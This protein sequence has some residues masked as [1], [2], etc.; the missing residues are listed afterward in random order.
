MTLHTYK[1]NL[2]IFCRSKP[3]FFPFHS[4]LSPLSFKLEKTG[5][6][7]HLQPTDNFKWDHRAADVNINICIW[8]SESQ[9]HCWL[10]FREKQRTNRHTKRDCAIQAGSID[11]EYML[12]NAHCVWKPIILPFHQKSLTPGESFLGLRSRNTNTHSI[13]LQRLVVRRVS[14]EIF[15]E[16]VGRIYSS[17][18]KCNW[19]LEENAKH[20]PINITPT[21]CGFCFSSKGHSTSCETLDSTGFTSAALP[22]LLLFPNKYKALG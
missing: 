5:L 21:F 17:D 15:L 19:S 13:S 8:R 10:V 22:P 4:R 1:Y 9:C 16:K 18:A 2:L 12:M 3:S 14:I 6:L 7:K 11:R 20:I